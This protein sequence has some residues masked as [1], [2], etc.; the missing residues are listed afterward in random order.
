MQPVR[1]PGPPMTLQ[2]TKG[3]GTTI[4]STFTAYDDVHPRILGTVTPLRSLFSTIP[5]RTYDD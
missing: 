4:K 1:I 3:Y 5:D 2:S